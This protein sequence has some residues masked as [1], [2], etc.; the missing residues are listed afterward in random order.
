[1]DA[2][3]LTQRRTE[4]GRGIASIGD[5]SM[6]VA[7]EEGWWLV[8]TGAP[9]PDMNMVLLHR[10]EPADLAHALERLAHVDCPALLMFAGAGL[11][12][13]TWLPTGWMD[14]GEMPIMAVDLAQ[15]P[16]ARDPRVRR[17][18]AADVE[19]LTALLAEAYGIEPDHAKHLPAV[20]ER[21]T[22][23]VLWLL[24]DGAAA[25]SMVATSRDGDSVS[26]WAMATPARLGRRGYGRALLA[27]VLHE[28]SLDGAEIGLLGATPAGFPLY[29]ATGWSIVE[30]WRVFTNATSAQFA[31]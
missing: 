8:L 22:N 14:A 9:S 13:T 30:Q 20:A 1:M 25:V 16:T 19:T 5:A 10:D 23:L 2:R 3:E 26:V 31:H 21:E 29:E 17:A 11:K 15:T 18:D 27:H 7:V 28:A 12:L 6:D 4:M 24:E